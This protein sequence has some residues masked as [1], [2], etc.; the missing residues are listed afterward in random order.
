[1]LLLTGHFQ[2]C[3]IINTAVLI[4]FWCTFYA[5]LLQVYLE[6]EFLA[7][8]GCTSSTFAD[9]ALEEFSKSSCQMT[10]PLQLMSVPVAL[11]LH[12]HLKL[13]FSFWSF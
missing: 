2:F 11:Q 13:S 5:F 9:N 10:L 1:M 7:H 4:V 8:K 3:A 12:K 6:V